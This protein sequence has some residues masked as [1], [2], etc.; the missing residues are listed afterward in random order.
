MERENARKEQARFQGE[1]QRNESRLADERVQA[2]KQYREKLQKESERR[3]KEQNDRKEHL[4]HVEELR[5]QRQKELADKEVGGDKGRE[6]ENHLARGRQLDIQ[7]NKEGRGA[8]QEQP[9]K[10]Q[11]HNGLDKLRAF[12]KSVQGK[13]GEQLQMQEKAQEMSRTR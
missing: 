6:I 10:E 9:Y 5:H 2:D 7:A 11:E 12:E 13:V 8:K 1:R 3:R 4:K